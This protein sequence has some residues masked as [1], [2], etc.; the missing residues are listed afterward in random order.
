LNICRPKL[1]L[2]IIAMFIATL[3]LGLAQ[4]S[5]VYAETANDAIKVD[6]NFDHNRTAF[7]LEGAHQNVTCETCH[8]GGVFKG[9]PT[10]CSKCHNG[11]MASGKTDNHP[12]SSAVCSDCH[13]NTNWAQVHVDHGK[14]SKDCFSCHDG[15]VAT[16]KNKNHIKSTTACENCHVVSTWKIAKFDHTQTSLPCEACHDGVRASGKP[17]THMRS[18]KDCASCH[19]TQDWKI[20]VF[21]HT[22]VVDGCVKCHNGKDATGKSNIH[23][24]T[25]DEC[26]NCHTT[27]SW[28]TNNIDHNDP[29]VKGQ[30][31][32]NCHDGR[33][34]QGQSPFHFKVDNSAV[35]ASG[36]LGA[37]CAV[38]HKSTTAWAPALF[39]H[40]LALDLP[41][42][43][44]CHNGNR[45]P[46]QG[47]LS[48]T[49]QHVP[50]S[51]NCTDCHSATK[52]DNWKGAKFVH[53]NIVTGCATCHNGTAATGKLTGPN[54]KHMPTTESCESCHGTSFMNWNFLKFDHTQ[55]SATCATCH[56]GNQTMPLSTKVIMGKLDGP[57][58]VH[59]SNPDTTTNDCVSCHKDS[60]FI[61]SIGFDH[62]QM[63]S[64]NCTDCHNG[65]TTISPAKL[66]KYKLPTHI[67]ISPTANCQDCHT[68][69]TN[70]TTALFDHSVLTPADTCE[71]C[72]DGVVAKG[73]PAGTDH[74]PYNAGTDCAACHNN[75]VNWRPAAMDHAFVTT[76]CLTCH[77]GTTKI[78]LKTLTSR[79]VATH[80]A[81]SLPCETCHTTS[82]WK[83]VIFD[84]A[85]A[86]V[87]MG[88]GTCFT[89]HN[90]TAAKG[91]LS[92][93]GKHIPSSNTCDACHK[94]FTA[95][96]PVT[97]VDTHISEQATPCKSCH[98]GILATGKLTGPN[99]K[100]I[101][102]T[103]DCA[104]C[105][106][107]TA[108]APVSASQ[109]HAD[110]TVQATKC[111]TCHNGVDAT[112]KL[113]GPN[114]KHIPVTSECSNCHTYAPG[115]KVTPAVLHA[116]PSVVAQPCQTCHNGTAA[117]G[118]TT[119]GNIHINSSNVCASCHVT[120]LWKPIPVGGVDHGQVIGTCA[121]CHNGTTAKTHTGA[122]HPL[123]PADANCENCHTTLNWTASAKPDHT[124]I[125]IVK[126]GQCFTCHNGAPTKGKT[127]NH[128]A[129]SNTCDTCHTIVAFKP[130]VFDH[131]DPG[132]K[133]SVAGSCF[134]CHNG[135]RAP[136]DGK[137][138]APLGH[139]KTSEM[140][141][142]CHAIGA[143]W[144][145]KVK[146]HTVADPVV[147]AATC[148]S[149]HDGSH[150]PATPKS[151][152]HFKTST[153]C[154][155]CHTLLNWTVGIGKFNHSDAVAAAATCVSCHDGAANHAP[156]LGKSSAPAPGHLPT[157]NTCETCH[158][159]TA[160]KPAAFDHTTV[161]PGTCFTCHNGTKATGKNAATHFA[162]SN[163]CDNCHNT[164]V[165]KPAK[166]PFHGID[167]GITG[168]CVS[169][170]SGTRPPAI[171]KSGA[172]IKS[173][174][175]C[176]ACHD[177]K[178]AA[179]KAFAVDHTAVVGNCV[180]CHNGSIASG[181][182]SISGKHISTSDNCT[183]C[184]GTLNTRTKAAAAWKVA[185]SL[186]RSTHSTTDLIGTCVSC[187][188]GTT[189]TLSFAPV[190]FKS[191][192]HIV[193]TD[194]CTFCHTVFTSWA[195]SIVDHTQLKGT[196][197]VTCHNGT[198][199]TG[200]LTS[201]LGKHI[202]TNDSCAVCHVTKDTKT[203]T[204]TAWKMT[205]ALMIASHSEVQGTCF[206]CHNGTTNT[207]SFAPVSFMSATHLI[208][209]IA[210]DTCHALPAWKPAL[211][212]L[213]LSLAYVK[214]NAPA[215]P[216]NCIGCHKQN[217]Q[218]I[219]FT[220]PS[221]V[222]D[223]AACHSGKFKASSHIKFGNTPY[224]A[225]E[226]RDCAGACHTYT[227]SALTTISKNLPSHHKATDGSF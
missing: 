91:K 217:N 111:S 159:T 133:V 140:C 13:N 4:V 48:V 188:S 40:N 160:W 68:S 184:H 136:A 181:K 32:L 204:N 194:A 214:H 112:G 121:S 88:G 176:E 143:T 87:I 191:A 120:T 35:S 84:H 223:C 206:S 158:S 200:K 153:D 175:A 122:T 125:N 50:A 224:T 65:T 27:V 151:N 94:A 2:Q 19:K 227:S 74:I 124:D 208:T 17:F 61:P 168:T 7:P 137:I 157:S 56:V 89:C 12:K 16:G 85:T 29:M 38:C 39:D 205:K 163:T 210:C 109:I 135:L 76:N 15:K 195:A 146:I 186:V 177:T 218:K 145:T 128:F 83:G 134:T 202:T 82:S 162:S 220:S 193:S 22:G 62:D 221:L 63:T 212:Y 105:H 131:A 46:A 75:F 64:T 45:L 67:K 78:Y 166:S 77:N 178:S 144:V 99:K 57:K 81:T 110:A 148:I 107:T 92:I 161:L 108:W 139:V 34:A 172:H 51:N 190:S 47:K 80:V 207:L 69:F 187:H 189:N 226:L 165:W 225:T 115:W 138:A 43:V 25:S 102:S 53:V 216:T 37:D 185:K 10:E 26:Q 129:S 127:P 24:V 182:L 155:S 54:N 119:N 211:T 197:C 59:L 152:L 73:K 156:A 201:T 72:H 213:H 96:K 103:T 179:W 116:D 164:T 149:C 90:G 100:H 70:W 11:E 9:V 3:W 79:N 66:L 21:D 44:S 167:I 20:G 219:T 104:S 86:G 171:T 97:A 183:N 52:F 180:S 6:Q 33:R 18:S 106:V 14:I 30:A 123:P 31:C 23:I 1:L 203:K 114:K 36:A 150:P 169:C 196:S 142:S 101:A 174:T 71:S 199:A 113:T 8:A 215:N 98:D 209:T 192:A 42:C 93:T 118:K 60:T 141:E 154:A 117:T 222:P 126:P 198:K 49:G 95:F 55:T 5:P 173:T 170:H 28:N 130:A 41:N 58:G 132:V 147:V